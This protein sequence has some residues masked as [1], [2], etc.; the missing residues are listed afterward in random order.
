MKLLTCI[1]QAIRNRVDNIT[2]VLDLCN[3]LAMRLDCEKFKKWVDCEL[4][5]YD[6]DSDVPDYREVIYLKCRT[7]YRTRA[8]D[9]YGECMHE[10][11]DHEILWP[12]PAVVTFLR[13]PF[14]FYNTMFVSYPDSRMGK[15]ELHKRIN[16]DEIRRSGMHYGAWHVIPST[17]I[18]S[19]IDTV[20]D[21][22][23]YFVY[24]L[25]INSKLTDNE[26]I[27]QIPTEVASE[28]Y[29][30]VFWDKVYKPVVTDLC[31]WH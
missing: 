19:M 7:R 30:K 3:T 18:N 15:R 9:W 4:N 23:L 29:E 10:A 26:K 21:K 2:T 8:E 22:V 17:E 25:K 28:L 12:H 31:N 6:E 16:I 13:R 1:E 24:Y 14:S 11:V 27:E 5:G 20:L